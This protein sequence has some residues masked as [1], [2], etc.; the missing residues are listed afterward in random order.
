MSQA[1]GLKSPASVV[2]S[3][4]AYRSEIDKV[5]SSIGDGC[6]QGLTHRSSVAG[7]YAQYATWC[8]AQ[9]KHPRNEVQFG[10]ALKSQ[11]YGQV[12]DCAGRFWLGLTTFMV[13]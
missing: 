13:T 3:I 2:A 5:A 1:E 4:T 9:D 8:K 12:H 7:L 10:N 6:N 11:G